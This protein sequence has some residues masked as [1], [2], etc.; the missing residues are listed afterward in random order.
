[1]TNMRALIGGTGS[2]RLVEVP[3]PEAGPGQVRIRMTA[4]RANP[5]DLAVAAG[6]LADHGVA[7]KLIPTGSASTW[8]GR[9]TRWAKESP[10]GSGTR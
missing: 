1:M 2:P 6:T 7:R 10:T 4:A 5:F 9:S 8:P 3:V